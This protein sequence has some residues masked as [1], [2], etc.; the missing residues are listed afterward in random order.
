MVSRIHE[1]LQSFSKC[2]ILVIGDLILDQYTFGSVTRI[3]PEAP[4]QVFDFERDEF[5]LGGAANV[6]HNMAK[7][8]AKISLMGVVGNDTA[9][10]IL[11]K[12]AKEAG[13]DITGVVTD[14]G[15]PT[16]LKTR[17]IAQGHHLLRTDREK[18]I[19]LSI[20][21]QAKFLASL[22][23]EI[24][25]FQAVVI[26]DYAKGMLPE[27][28][29]MQIIELA[30][31]HEKK[32]MVGPKGKD[33]SRYR[34]AY[35]LSAN[36]SETEGVT[37]ITLRNKKDIARAGEQLL[38]DLQLG[39]MLITL[40]AEGMYLVARNEDDFYME[41]Q[42]QEVFDVVGAGDT[43]LSVMSLMLAAGHPWKNA[44]TM[45]NTA[46]GIVV[47]K[48]GI[49]V[50]YPDE[51][52]K[53]MAP[54]VA[55]YLDKIMPVEQAISCVE[56]Q[57]HH[58]KLVVFTWGGF[59]VNTLEQVRFLEHCKSCGDFLVVG[60]YEQSEIIPGLDSKER[61]QILAGLAAVDTIVLTTPEQVLLLMQKIQP[62]IVVHH[63]DE[64]VKTIPE[65][66]K[67]AIMAYPVHPNVGLVP[68]LK[69]ISTHPKS[70]TNAEPK[71][72]NAEPKP[73]E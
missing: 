22:E 47:G 27:Q 64:L 32:V 18:R 13:I 58:G 55:H 56:E 31:K 36:R 14:A 28:F 68:F 30:C 66:K 63:T 57:R 10:R 54:G 48:L 40:G 15:R 49:K 72:A 43:V 37:G 21:L 11:L 6:A 17:L 5:R 52:A 70:D 59:E 29:C 2:Q 39:G 45:A 53:K 73:E 71:P 35:V 24:D 23:Q 12:L 7:L 19:P 1:V 51:L 25:H 62:D 16:T 60:L 33:W 9:G 4:I 20:E 34:G 50:V 67:V 65:S 26:S 44:V 8:E 46:A 38:E 61:S 41:A 42:A 3:S 69:R